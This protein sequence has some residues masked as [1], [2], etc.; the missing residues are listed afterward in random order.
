MLLRRVRPVRP[1]RLVDIGRAWQIFPDKII[2]HNSIGYHL[3]CIEV[4]IRVYPVPGKF[5]IQCVIFVVPRPEGKAGVLAEPSNLKYYFLFKF[6]HKVLIIGIDGAC[7]H[8]VLP[9]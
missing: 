4:K 7:L 3:T 8:K 9:D 5:F 1:R 6:P 2:F